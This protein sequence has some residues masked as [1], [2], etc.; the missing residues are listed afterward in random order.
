MS[1]AA[2]ISCLILLM[3]CEYW[4]ITYKD[5]ESLA[6]LITAFIVLIGLDFFQNHKKKLSPDSRLITDFLE[7]IP[8]DC[9]D[10]FYNLSFEDNPINEKF[11]SEIY[12]LRD[13]WV[14]IYLYDKKIEK[15]KLKLV[16]SID[17]FSHDIAKY[18]IELRSN[19][20]QLQIY[21]DWKIK[22]P[23]RYKKALRDLRKDVEKI[24]V[25]YDKLM[26]LVKRLLTG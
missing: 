16:K 18:T 23:K 12:E 20:N 10:Y 9:I 8:S 6:G 26:E 19:S 2:K 1:F 24:T 21:P 17:N 25:A 15:V 7:T 3:V 11:L 13:S 5:P 4:F 14:P 22:E